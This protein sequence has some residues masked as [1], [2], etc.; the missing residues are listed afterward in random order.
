MGTTDFFNRLAQIIETNSLCRSELSPTVTHPEQ[1]DPYQPYRTLSHAANVAEFTDETETGQI[2]KLTITHTGEKKRYKLVTF[3]HDDPENPKNW[4]KAYKWY[5]TMVIALTCMCVAL[6]SS[7]IT[8]TIEQVVVEFDTTREIALLSV[9]MFVL[10]FG[11]GPMVFAPMSE[12]IGRQLVYASTL[13]VAIIFIIPCAVAKNIETL[14]VCRLLGGI[15][16][17]A[18]MTLV[19]DSFSMLQFLGLIIL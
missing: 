15:A 2:P 4:S 18:P 10:G 3:T 8:A 19:C 6:C 17:S 16:M 13:L 7:V 9:C 5:C 14:V 1:S 12:V 11:I